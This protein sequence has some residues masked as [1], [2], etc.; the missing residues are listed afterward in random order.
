MLKQAV[1]LIKGVDLVLHMVDSN[2]DLV[3]WQFYYRNFKENKPTEDF[4]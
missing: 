3:N 4:V 1:D 2:S